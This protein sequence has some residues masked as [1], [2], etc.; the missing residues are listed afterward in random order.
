[1]MLRFLNALRIEC[2]RSFTSS[3]FIIASV[4][5]CFTLFLGAWQDIA[6]GEGSVV[7]YYSVAL[8]ETFYILFILFCTLPHATSFCADWNSQF[9]KPYVIRAS[10]PNYQL[11]KIAACAVSGA[12]AV[13]LGQVL[14][15]IILLFFFPVVPVGGLEDANANQIYI[16]LLEEGH[17]AI[18][19]GALI[20]TISLC[21]GVFSVLALCISTV[22]PNLFVIV[23]TP[24]L[25]Y[26][27]LVNLADQLGMPSYLQLNKIYMARCN[28]GTPFTSFAY[29]VAFSV[30]VT[31]LLCVAFMFGSRRR[32]ERG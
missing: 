17:Y 9:I 6:Y 8:T 15:I 24:M 26:Y 7:Y 1:M 20:L 31:A 21:S 28:L 13:T 27:A 14:F 16:R 4:A 25:C 11:A 23:A 22:L 18:Y 3:G 32:F 30:I 10:F 12:S 5:V 19:F 29:V 2:K